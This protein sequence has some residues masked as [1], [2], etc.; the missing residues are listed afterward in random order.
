MCPSA[1]HVNCIV[2]GSRYNNACL[3]CDKHP[4]ATLPACETLCNDIVAT[5]QHF[6]DQMRIPE[7]DPDVD[8]LADHHFMLPLKIKMDVG[9]QAPNFKNIF[10]LDYDAYPGG[11]KAISLQL[12]EECCSCAE[13]CDEKCINRILKIECYDVPGKLRDAVCN[14]SNTCNGDCGNRQFQKRD[15]VKV[16]PFQEGEMGWGLKSVDFVQ[17]GTLVIE[18]LG[19]VINEEEMQVCTI[20]V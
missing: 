12:P 17:R 8:E 5:N 6:W 4:E 9:R 1:F 10:K 14:N 13:R 18:Y 3:I 20:L 16:Q 7:L 11:E 19:E 2:P 15:Y